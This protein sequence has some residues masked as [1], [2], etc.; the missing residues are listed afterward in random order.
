MSNLDQTSHRVVIPRYPN[1]VSIFH[2]IE[3]GSTGGS[4]TEA[5]AVFDPLERVIAFYEK[6]LGEPRTDPETGQA[7]WRLDDNFL[8]FKGHKSISIY[9]VLPALVSWLDTTPIPE[10]TQAII[11][12]SSSHRED[13][14]EIKRQD[15]EEARLRKEK[16]ENLSLEIINAGKLLSEEIK[17]GIF[18]HYAGMKKVV[19]NARHSKYVRS[20]REFYAVADSVETVRE[21]YG[22]H[23]VRPRRF[24]VEPTS[25]TI[26][27]GTELFEST[28]RVTVYAE[29][30]FLLSNK[31]GFSETIPQTIRSIIET[32][33]SFVFRP[34]R[35]ASKKFINEG[36]RQ[37]DNLN[38]EYFKSI[39]PFSIKRLI[40][41]P[42]VAPISRLMTGR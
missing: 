24:D 42:W 10:N 21:F 20:W 17:Q 16:E 5:F 35:D 3:D 37:L 27:S 14:E 26:K 41:N 40:I 23:Y 2:Y 30:P 1:E 39:K 9:P 33:I 36:L 31:A 22:K 4:S 12:I 34:E 25:W 29:M 28:R 6:I 13:P 11:S 15:R 7:S 32:E 8:A 19:S 38:Y 18:P